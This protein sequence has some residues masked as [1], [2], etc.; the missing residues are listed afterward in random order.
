MNRRNFLKSTLA[1]SAGLKAPILLAGNQ[2]TFKY[3]KVSL[4]DD[5][6]KAT[7]N[8]HG[9]ARLVS[10]EDIPSDA[11]HKKY[12]ISKEGCEDAVKTVRI[13]GTHRDKAIEKE[14]AQEIAFQ[15]AKR[16]REATLD[17][18]YEQYGDNYRKI[19]HSPYFAEYEKEQMAIYVDDMERIEKDIG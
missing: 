18:F 13:K 12:T 11:Y 1:L 17:F 19:V 4:P 14:R 5:T 3:E 8:A 6:I 16:L 15:T 2:D 10:I 7:F 9:F